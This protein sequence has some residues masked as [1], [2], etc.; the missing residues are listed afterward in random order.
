MSQVSPS[1]SP[2]RQPG[3]GL[4]LPHAETLRWFA[5]VYFL[6]L[7]ISLLLLPP[8]S[9]RLWLGSL[10][11]RGICTFASGL[12]LLWVTV[13]RPRREVALGLYALAV[14]PHL[15][16]AFEYAL[17]GGV[18]PA[19]TLCLLALAVLLSPL[20]PDRGPA[21][22]RPDLLG[23][24]LGAALLVQGFDL[25]SREAALI[26]LPAAL[27]VSPGLVGALL[28]GGGLAVLAAQLA[29]G[30][31]GA[32]GW[33]AHLFAG[34]VVLSLWAAQSALQEPLYWVLGIAAVLRGAAI[35]ALPWWGG[36]IRRFDPLAL[37]VRLALALIT[38]VLVPLMVVLPIVI[39]ATED[40]R[41]AR[42]LDQQ[43]RA[44]ATG[45]ALVAELLDDQRELLARLAADQSLPALPPEQLRERLRA[46][47][48][49]D[50]RLAALALYDATGALLAAAGSAPPGA[51][52]VP[53]PPT[54]PA[55]VTVG[56]P[57]AVG[58]SAAQAAPVPTGAGRPAT[59]VAVADPAALAA[60]LTRIPGDAGA[61]LGLV[62][63]DGLPVAA[64][65]A[66][67]EPM[68]DLDALW[69]RGAALAAG[70]PAAATAQSAQGL[71]LLGAAPVAESPWRVVVVI[72]QR[73]VLADL[74]PVRQLA[75][76]VSVLTALAAG[77][78]GWW[79]AGRLAAPIRDLMLA[80]GR[81]ADGERD[82]ALPGGGPTEL[83]RLSVAVG[84]MAASLD[85]RLEERSQLAARLQEQNQ[86][87][88]EYEEARA[89][90]IRALSHDLR[91]PLTA[92]LANAQRLVRLLGRGE[93][94]KEQKI[95]Q[96]M[97][98]VARRMNGMIQDLADALRFDAGAIQPRRELVHIPALAA[99]LSGQLGDPDQTARIQILVADEVPP[100]AADPAQLD[101]V[102]TN[103]LSNALKYAPADTPVLVSVHQSGPELVVGV[104]DRGIGMSQ[105][106][107]AQLFRRYYR[108]ERAQAI[109]SGLG[110][111]LYVTRALVEAHG[112]RIWVESA[113]GEGSTFRFTLPLAGV[114][115]GEAAG[116]AI[117][118]SVG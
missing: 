17:L 19:V 60:A 6:L 79:L 38:A 65:E 53:L 27:G 1:A 26:M 97:V 72:P 31:P 83:A 47:R 58:R 84:M 118:R 2:A 32:I 33:A 76:A 67:G 82:V 75:F 71:R 55:A 45:A 5:G 117:Q 100:V 86:E 43:Q 44:A 116:E 30:L 69:A 107:Q 111:G 24:V 81:I 4:R 34:G 59:L 77:L 48:A 110:L 29:P 56:P 93:L 18:T 28:V 95:A 94:P 8:G 61:R 88:R 9:L 15:V 68:A 91:N 7:G 89:E 104:T 36:R 54:G 39:E 114:A 96:S 80:V 37:R 92:L 51:P 49:A 23:L 10:W 42:T 14:A 62:T 21:E 16:V 103:L 66:A 101:R 52:G 98:G 115:A 102:L 113:P 63:A 64:P 105:E 40:R 20:L 3:R 78:G 22:Q 74:A 11:L 70:G 25:L 35:M 41:T 13:L 106:E 12:L 99:E 112:G 85:A 46:A 109:S 73:V 50:G 87:L 57:W 90:S 108:A